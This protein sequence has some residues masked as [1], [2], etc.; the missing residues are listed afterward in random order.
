[1]TPSPPPRPVAS[2][3]AAG[4]G[5]AGLVI[6]LAWPLVLHPGSSV[7][8]PL[9]TEGPG[10]I[11]ARTD[12]DLLM[13]I[14]A[15]TA[16]AVVAEPFAIFQANIF[17]PAA[18][19]LASS[20]HLLGLLP[21]SGPIF[22]ATG[23]AVLTYN[24][25]TLVVVWL[26]AFTTFLLGRAWSGS[27]VA[28]F[29]GGALFALGG[30]VP[31]SFLRLHTSA[32][33]LYPLVL[34]L[35]W[36]VAETPTG[37][38]FTA[39]VLV[40]AL[41]AMSGIYVAF[42]L[43]AL[44]GAALPSLVAHARRSGHSG[45]APVAALLIGA[46]PLA[47]VAGPYLRMQAAGQ[48][49][50]ETAAFDIIAFTSNTLPQ[51]LRREWSELGLLGLAL[52][53]VG[54]ASSRGPTGVRACLLSIALGGVVLALGTHATIPGSGLP[55]PYEVLM[56]IVPGFSGMRAPGR[57]LYLTSLALSVLAALGAAHAIRFA[58]ERWH[59]SGE[60][61][62]QAALVILA[63]ALVPVR[64]ER[65]PLPVAADPLAG[66]FVGSH[67]W[68]AKHADSGP[69][70]DLPVPKSAMDGRAMLAT[71]RAMLGSTL[72]W[73]PL[74]NGYSG[75]P[76]PGHAETVALAR[77]LPDPEALRDLCSQT[78]LRWIVVHH[79]LFPPGS[80][81]AWANAEATLPATV[82]RRFGRDTIYDV[83]CQAAETGRPTG[84][85]PTELDHGTAPPHGEESG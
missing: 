16:H 65:W 13:W 26:A 30:E 69:V 41:Q 24:V 27:A 35:A 7:V 31:L 39:L 71:G 76:P 55:S 52:A 58:G 37:T 77:R 34:L 72:H 63:V 25:T 67:R 5:Y 43:A 85:I 79:G 83:D 19:T 61:A 70:L 51:I 64:A 81:A 12:L 36:Y 84:A 32:L 57:F 40:A 74:L 73:F 50:E 15:W 78:S 23:N 17:H 9:A 28:G 29:L 38:R 75:H 10:K 3:A 82:A 68:L 42:G 48:L 18:D 20:E 44:A 1:M 46:L 49:P 2:T 54:L 22:W 45:A 47:L 8:D 4:L 62:V 80:E 66:I 59:R 14:L 21:V 11:W 60:R 56:W 53:G 33:H 6:F